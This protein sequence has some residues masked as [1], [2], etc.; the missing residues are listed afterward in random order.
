MKQEYGVFRWAL[1]PDCPTALNQLPSQ[2]LL[3]L[4]SL[5]YLLCRLRCWVL[6]QG[7]TRWVF[8]FCVLR[9]TTMP[10]MEKLRLSTGISV[11]VVGLQGLAGP[12]Y[13]PCCDLILVTRQQK[14]PRVHGAIIC[15]VGRSKGSGASWAFLGRG[16]GAEEEFPSSPSKF[17]GTL[18]GAV[19]LE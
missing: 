15:K 8:V 14:Y 18:L 2:H 3:C 11:W 4:W 1:G 19:A 16:W 17:N 12:L 7:W 10:R 9:L 6:C 13:S 5:C